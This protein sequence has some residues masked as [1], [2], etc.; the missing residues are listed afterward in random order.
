MSVEKQLDDITVYI[1]N[2]HDRVTIIEN[3]IIAFESRNQP[4]SQEEQAIEQVKEEEDL[5]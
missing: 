1:Q 3:W 5:N 2:L 4:T